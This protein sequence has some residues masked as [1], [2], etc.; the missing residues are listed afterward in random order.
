VEF[1]DNLFKVENIRGVQLISWDYSIPNPSKSPL[2][3]KIMG[4]ADKGASFR[5]FD[6]MESNS[7]CIC[8][9]CFVAGDHKGHNYIQ[10]TTTNGCCDCGNDEAWNEK[11][12]CTVHASIISKATHEILESTRSKYIEEGHLLLFIYFYLLGKSN[13]KSLLEE[14]GNQ[15]FKHLTD[16]SHQ[17]YEMKLLACELMESKFPLDYPNIPLREHSLIEIFFRLPGDQVRSYPELINWMFEVFPVEHIRQKIIVEYCGKLRRIKEM[18]SADHPLAGLNFQFMSSA[19]LI[20]RMVKNKE[21][22]PVQAPLM[23]LKGLREEDILA[24]PL[25]FK[26]LY[27][28]L[29]YIN[30]MKSAREYHK[31]HL[32]LATVAQLAAYREITKAS[33]PLPFGEGYIP[34]FNVDEM[35]LKTFYRFVA[36]IREEK[37]LI[38]KCL[39][40]LFHYIFN[41]G[42]NLASMAQERAFAML[43]M[44]YL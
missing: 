33:E 29:D 7:S 11:G 6:C 40:E 31:V 16:I 43:V 25:A 1:V 19:K 14:Y 23:K 20:T 4:G 8:E 22:E 18:M 30:N 37:K 39:A 32:E 12:F 27:E 44:A 34:M 2:C 5:C 15:V 42:E 13:R 3:S 41:A 28:D 10:Y 21:I 35:F 36:N 38:C 9:E 26:K 24:I 17:N